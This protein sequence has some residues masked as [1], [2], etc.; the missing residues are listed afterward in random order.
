EMP[1]VKQRFE[2]LGITTSGMPPGE[3]AQ[4]QRQ[5]IVKW[6]ALIKNAKVTVE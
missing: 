2:Q 5:E 4:F 1:D 3:F 6:T